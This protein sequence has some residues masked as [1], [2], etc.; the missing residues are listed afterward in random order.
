MRIAR[1][2]PSVSPRR[3]GDP[4]PPPSAVEAR[5]RWFASPCEAGGGGSRA[6]H[7]RRRGMVRQAQSL[8]RTGA[9]ALRDASALAP[10]FTKKRRAGD[11]GW[12]RVVW[13]SARLSGYRQIERNATSRVPAI[14]IRQLNH[15]GVSP[16][17]PQAGGGKAG[18]F[19]PSPCDGVGRSTSPIT[20]CVGCTNSIPPD[21]TARSHRP[22]AVEHRDCPPCGGDARIMLQV[23]GGGDGGFSIPQLARVSGL[24]CRGLCVL[25]SAE[26]GSVYATISA[27]SAASPAKAGVQR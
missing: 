26:V 12:P 17:G 22:R 11:A 6:Q 16:L 19:S 20:P 14:V 2:A 7:A 10:I 27:L 24:M 4:P 23:R 18:V 15:G 3:R 13:A 25:D 1:A 8:I 21:Q 5:R 9:I